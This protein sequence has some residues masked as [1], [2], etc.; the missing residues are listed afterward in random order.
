MEAELAA[1][2]QERD[3]MASALRQRSQE[4]EERALALA[5]AEEALARARAEHAADLRR[6]DRLR[7]DVAALKRDAMGELS[8]RLAALPPAV[9]EGTQGWG[10][11]GGA[12]VLALREA[13]AAH[14]EPQALAERLAEA[15]RRAEKRE[16]E[17]QALAARLK[18]AERRAEKR[19]AEAQL[20]AA[21]L[22][23]AERGAGRL[24]DMAARLREAERQAQQAQGL[25]SAARAEVEAL[26][27]STS[28]RI[29]TPLRSVLRALSRG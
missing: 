7:R 19:T 1:A 8:A 9:L 15:T 5:A 2:R 3:R 26:R 22:R 4:A 24:E 21:R 17:A 23:A 25:A 18:D 16:D 11:P 28:W 29:T 12:E 6:L 14:G 13:V 10:H 27:R 20:L